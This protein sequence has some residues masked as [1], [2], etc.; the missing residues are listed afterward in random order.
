MANIRRMFRKKKRNYRRRFMKRKRPIGSSP[1]AIRFFKL[2]RVY[3]LQLPA[4]GNNLNSYIDNNPNTAQDWSNV[5]GLFEMYR[6]AGIK[7]TFVPAA[8]VN[9]VP[10]PLPVNNTRFR[11]VY[12][13]LDTNDQLPT[14]NINNIIQYENL[15]IRNTYSMWSVYYKMKRRLPFAGTAAMSTS[16]YT[17][18]QSPI[19][20]QGIIALFE[21][22]QSQV[23]TDLGKM[24]VT[25]YICA[26][27]RH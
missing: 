4:G 24:I 23:V 7:L 9:N 8:N 11:P 22:Q 14:V 1:G 6:V 5:A 15:K 2:R 13:A 10:V 12:I 19:A 18:C 17:S 21:G 3:D 16:G 26:R 25:M 27:N 20:T